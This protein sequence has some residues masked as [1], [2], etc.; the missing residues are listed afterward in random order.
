MET[1]VLLSL[2]AGIGFNVAYLDYNRSVLSGK[3][4]PNGATWG[5][6]SAGALVSTGSYLS[7]TGDIWKSL[8]P[9]S[10]VFFCIATFLFALNKRKFKKIDKGD[11]LALMVGVV[12][13][14]I[15]YV[16]QS[17]TYANMIAQ[18][19]ILLGFVPIWRAI[20]KDPTVEHH[21]PWWIW[22]TAYCVMFVVV[23]MRWNHWVDLVYPVNCL[24]LHLSVPVLSHVRERQ[25]AP[26]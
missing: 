24:I 3:T 26:Y 20:W 11:S 12:A 15:W 18:I 1:S 17:A 19:G 9:L 2:I 8:I 7:M 14:V 6:W 23:I 5:I 16:Y 13:V 21:R 22:G 25:I 10:N 4:I